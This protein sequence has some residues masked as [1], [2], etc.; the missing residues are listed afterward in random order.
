MALGASKSHDSG[1][2][3]TIIRYFNVYGPG[4]S[5]IFVV[6]AMIQKAV[7]GEPL[8]VFDSGNQTRCFTF[9]DDAVNGTIAALLDQDHSGEVFNI[10][11]PVETTIKSLAE[12]ILEETLEFQSPGIEFIDASKKYGSYEDIIRRV[13]DVSKARTLL[14]WE[15]QIDLLK[16]IK[17][18]IKAAVSDS[19]STIS[20]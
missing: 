8:P 7:S 5:P 12:L 14:D 2:P 3:I 15:P 6:P 19:P 20:N 10:G 1:F 16:G 18:T 4:Q 13:P 17:L 11:N 9:V